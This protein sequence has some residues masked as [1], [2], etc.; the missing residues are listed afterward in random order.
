MGGEQLLAF[1]EYPKDVDR[2]NRDYLGGMQHDVFNVEREA[3]DTPVGHVRSCGVDVAGPHS[4]GD[5]FGRPIF[6]TT[7]V[8]GASWR[9]VLPPRTSASSARRDR[10]KTRPRSTDGSPKYRCSLKK[11]Q[12]KF[13][14]N[15][16][17]NDLTLR[18]YRLWR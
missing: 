15:A 12:S 6:T 9:P 7:T 11:S 17:A 2:A 10:P 5:R 3:L 14:G 18:R 4:L 13:R 16:K 1:F 8:S